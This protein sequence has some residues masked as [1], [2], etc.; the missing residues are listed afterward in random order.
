MEEEKW[1]YQS[2]MRRKAQEAHIGKDWKTAESYYRQLLKNEKCGD[3]VANF[4]ALLR[5]TSRAE[6]ALRMYKNY[7]DK[8]EDIGWGLFLNATNCA[9]EVGDAENAMEWIKKGINNNQDNDELKRARARVERMKGNNEAALSILMGIK[10]KKGQELECLLEIGKIF[11][12]KEE[13]YRALEYY[14]KAIEVSKTDS[15]ALA[16]AIRVTEIV[17]GNRSSKTI[18]RKC[19]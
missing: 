10:N 11:Q 12:E 2:E 16:N 8:G 14:L 7:I 18:N 3:D 1:K 6:E 15:R 17:G 19:F 13:H 5:A 9:I 4:G